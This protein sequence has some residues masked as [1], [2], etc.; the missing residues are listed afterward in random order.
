MKLTRAEF[1]KGAAASLALAP[2]S[3]LARE[4]RAQAT[5]GAAITVQY[6]TPVIR[7]LI[8]TSGELVPAIGLGTAQDFGEGREGAAFAARRDVIRTL[9]E[10]GGTVIDTAPV[11]GTAEPVIGRALAELGMRD[12]AFIATK[13]SISGEQAG[14]DQMAKSLVDLKTQKVECMMV[15]NL[16]DTEIHLKTLARMKGEGKIKYIGAT[17][18]FAGAHERMVETMQKHRLDWIQIDYALDNRDAENRILPL[19]RDKGVAVMVNLPFGRTRLFSKVRGKPL[20][21]WAV[22]ELGCTSWAQLF[23][24]Y[25]LANEAVTV[26]I[27]GTNNPAHMKD[28]LGAMH[29]AVPTPDQARRMIAA[30][31][32]A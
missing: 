17:T 1:L 14:I 25:V 30:V 8:P 28:N 6:D 15:H 13:V 24:K 10:G 3:L 4:S 29:G 9:I 31:E 32:A 21:G 20:P 18:S 5:N 22:A 2:N 12:K 19:A 27:P 16:R 23:L 11:Y 26:A 7:R